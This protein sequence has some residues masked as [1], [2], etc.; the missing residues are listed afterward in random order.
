ME[1]IQTHHRQ[2]CSITLPMSSNGCNYILANA[3]PVTGALYSLCPPT[4]TWQGRYIAP[5]S[6]KSLPMHS[7]KNLVEVVQDIYIRQEQAP[8]MVNSR[9][10]F[11]WNISP[12]CTLVYPFPFITYCW[13]ILKPTTWQTTSYIRSRHTACSRW[14][15][16][17]TSSGWL[18]R[19]C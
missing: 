16:P 19:A 13:I 4:G 9:V 2:H 18:A 1:C 10:Q 12:C 11:T 14:L 6:A 8:N 3:H 5:Y 17:E 15:L 7:W